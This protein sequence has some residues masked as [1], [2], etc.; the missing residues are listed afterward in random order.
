MTGY[1]YAGLA[2]PIAVALM[3]FVVGTLY[4]KET[5]KVRIWDEVGEVETT[6]NAERETRK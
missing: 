4:L 6:R 5:H 1:N 2:F 3:T